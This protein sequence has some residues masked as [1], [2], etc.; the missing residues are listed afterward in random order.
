MIL[1]AYVDPDQ[2]SSPFFAST[3]D[4]LVTL[5]IIAA[6]VAVVGRYAI[7]RWGRA[8]PTCGHRVAAGKFECGFCGH[9]F[10]KDED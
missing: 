5:L 8:C 3:G 9:S 10:L 2:A 7:R 6:I 1:L 4:T